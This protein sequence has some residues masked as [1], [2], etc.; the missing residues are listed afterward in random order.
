LAIV[1]VLLRVVPFFLFAWAEQRISSGLASVLNATTPLQTMAVGVIALKA[2]RLN[3]AQVGGLLFGFLGVLVI[4]G[5]WRGIGFTQDLTADAACLI[6]TACYGL[7]F[8]YL[9]RA[10]NAAAVTYLTPAVGVGLGVI[11]LGEPLMWNQ[12]LGATLVVAGVMVSHGRLC[13]PDRR[14]RGLDAPADTAAS[15]EPRL[16]CGAEVDLSGGNARLRMGSPGRARLGGEECRDT[17]PA[18]PAR[19]RTA[20]RPARG[21]EAD[22]APTGPGW[23]YWPG[24]C[25]EPTHRSC[26]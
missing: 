15:S 3:R 17:D 10:A 18:T 14:R 7:A 4:I 25:R 8:V 6:A 12:P 2:E 23:R 19:G 5:P 16:D 1:A 21:A 11:L 22:V 9:R 13:V 20:P 24:S 26:G